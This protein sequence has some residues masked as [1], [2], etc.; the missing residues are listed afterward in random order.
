MLHVTPC[1]GI[2]THMRARF[3]AAF[4]PFSALMQ[5]KTNRRLEL[6]ILEMKLLRSLETS[7]VCRLKTRCHIPQNLF[8]WAT[9]RDAG[10]LQC[11]DKEC[12][13]I[14]GVPVSRTVDTSQ[15]NK[16]MWNTDAL[17][18]AN[19]KHLMYGLR[20]TWVTYTVLSNCLPL[21]LGDMLI[22]FV[23]SQNKN[24]VA[25]VS[26]DT[27]NKADRPAE[28]NT[29]L[30]IVAVMIPTAASNTSQFVPLRVIKCDWPLCA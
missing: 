21:G 16:C 9:H 29:C 12:Y 15:N 8:S 11:D 30:A 25:D 3:D 5:L 19:S 26:W 10:G 17:P 4:A 23:L 1:V 28:S 22:Q 7:G 2:T 18:T 24:M 13:T 20:L 14:G 27:L 6:L